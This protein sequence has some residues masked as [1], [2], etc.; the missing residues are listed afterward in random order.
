MMKAVSKAGIEKILGEKPVLEKQD[1]PKTAKAL[2]G[3]DYN[4]NP[5]LVCDLETNLPSNVRYAL[6]QR[7]IEIEV[8][9]SITEKIDYETEVICRSGSFI[10]GYADILIKYRIDNRAHGSMDGYEVSQH[11]VGDRKQVLVELKPALEDIGAVLRQLKTYESILR[12][13][14][15]F[16]KVIVTYD[17]QNVDL[18]EYLKHEGVRL[19]RFE[20]N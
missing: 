6:E 18:I 11:L 17:Q 19:I 20:E 10:V 1:V 13:D 14:G 2:M 5:V 15:K 9:E 16:E 4:G 7:G 12:G 3:K 8:H